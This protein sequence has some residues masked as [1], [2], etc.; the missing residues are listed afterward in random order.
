M[1][2]NDGRF[3]FGLYNELAR[4]P[5]NLVFSP[6]SARIA[7]AMALAGARGNTERSMAHALGL[8]LGA[9]G[10]AAM[11]A[12]LTEWGVRHFDQPAPAGAVLRLSNRLWLQRD[13]K[14]VE[15]FLVRLAD[16][17]RAPPGAL[18][19][20]AAPALARQAINRWVAEQT[21]GKIPEL[22]AAGQI[23]ADTRLVLT[24]TALFKAGWATP[25][26]LHHTKDE[27]F[28]RAD[29]TQV[30]VE[31]MNRFDT[32]AAAEIPGGCIVDV[33]YKVSPFVMT[34]VVPA[35][36]D[37]LPALEREL[38][39]GAFARWTR[40]LAEREVELALLRFTI[41]DRRQLEGMLPAIGFGD[42]FSPRADF[43]GIAGP[44]GE[45]VLGSVT[46]CARIEVDE[47]GTVAAAATAIEVMF[48]SAIAYEPPPPLVVRCDRPFAF[49]IRDRS[50]DGIVFAGRVVDPP[51]RTPR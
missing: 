35:R 33:P 42:A 23:S 26:E 49:V 39:A 29:G 24:N 47:Q 19:F 28:T 21:A 37:G 50:N 30:E 44:P 6:A 9:E 22:L 45:L 31:L 16:S 48:G 7:L 17:Y 1:V 32:L 41:E 46:H 15:A 12:L 34:L 51:R 10:H 14:L 27:T 25:F 2:V 8:E 20:A 18:D 5:G 40:K 38:A 36:P 43:S 13:S 3:A 4:A 11:A